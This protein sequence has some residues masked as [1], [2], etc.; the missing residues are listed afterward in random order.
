MHVTL[1][2]QDQTWRISVADNGIGI[3]EDDLEGVFG[4]F[5]TLTQGSGDGLGLAIV[6]RLIDNLGGEVRCQSALGHGTA[7]LVDLPR[8]P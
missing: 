3:A 1:A 2:A 6:R 7:F 5:R 4:M 8:E